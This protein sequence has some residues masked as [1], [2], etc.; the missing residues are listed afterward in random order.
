MRT[1]LSWSVVV[2]AAS[3]S[4]A[5]SR[6]VQPPSETVIT[7]EHSNRFPSQLGPQTLARHDPPE[8]LARRLHWPPKPWKVPGQGSYP[9]VW[10][11]RLP[12]PLVRFAQLLTLAKAALRLALQAIALAQDDSPDP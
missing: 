11:P 10:A 3:R 5:A 7:L 9:F 8:A 1:K 2:V 6:W 4:L 12:V